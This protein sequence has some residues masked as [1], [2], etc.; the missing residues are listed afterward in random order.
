MQPEQAAASGSAPSAVVGRVSFVSGSQIAVR[1]PPGGQAGTSVRTFLAIGTEG[2]LAI[3]IVAEL[4]ADQTADGHEGAVTG[5][6]DLLGEIAAGSFRRGVSL[7]PAIGNAVLPLGAS[8]LHAVFDAAGRDLIDIGS[9]HQ[10]AAIPALVSLDDMLLKHFAIFGS[11]GA[12]KSSGVAVILRQILERRRDLRVVVLDPHNEYGSCFGKA[13]RVLGPAEVRLPFWLFR[14]EEFVEVVFGRRTDMQAEIALLSELVPI[15]KAEYSRGRGPATV[16]TYRQVNVQAPAYTVDF[17]V[18]YSMDDL[19]ALIQSR[20]GKL[21]NGDVALRYQRLRAQLE[22]ARNNSRYAFMFDESCGD[23][24]AGI[25]SELLSLGGERSMTVLQLAGFP[26]EVLDAVV[27]VV[28][29]LVFEIGVWSDGAVPIQ[30]VCEEAHRYVHA[31]RAVGFRPA[32]DGLARIAKEGR[33][34][35]VSLGV[36]TQRPAELDPTLISQCSS[37]FAMRLAN[38]E[39]Q[40]SVRAAVSDAAS[41]L[42]GFLPSLGVREALA[43]GEAVPMAMRLRFGELP[44]DAVPHSHVVRSRFDP[45]TSEDL[46]AAVVARW[47]GTGLTAVPAREKPFPSGAGRP[48]PALA[49]GTAPLLGSRV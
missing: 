43:F 2:S 18:P 24:M 14:F 4:A 9:L 22:T 33:K 45:R 47:R 37:I 6:V 11:T 12:G 29:R 32:R 21:E 16:A 36:V 31:D 23:A 25:L 42:L 1:F 10:D 30:L 26:V 27:S 7:Y 35:C 44:P 34:Y 28:F 5:R 46:A 40:R 38:E 39:D 48:R 3:G 13:A 20:A 19:L 49:L 17:P 41:R 8:E 15:A